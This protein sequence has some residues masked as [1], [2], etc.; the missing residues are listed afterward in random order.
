MISDKSAACI[1][2]AISAVVVVLLTGLAVLVLQGLQSRFAQEKNSVC[3]TSQFAHVRLPPN[4]LIKLHY[5]LRISHDM[6]TKLGVRYVAIG[7]TLLSIVRDGHL[8]PWDD[9]GDLAVF[10]DDYQKRRKELATEM[11]KNRVH[12]RDPFKV[13]DLG[14]FQ[15][16]LDDDHPLNA[17][18]PSEDKPFVDW[19][20]IKKHKGDI[21]GENVNHYY[22]FASP[23]QCMLWPKD[24]HTPDEMFPLRSRP[25]KI[26]SDRTALRHNLHNSSVRLAV[27]NIT[28]EPLNRSYGSKTDP[29]QWR[30]CYLA[31]SHR[32]ASLFVKPCQLTAEQKAQL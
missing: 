24:Y 19:M 26:F 21:N 10:A 18:F 16:V 17:Q 3:S 1:G 30:T 4:Y 22:H 5:L 6:F 13:A 25:L 31:S 23:R 11:A 8:T 15:L 14:V 12:L 2:V 29:E 27:P 20:L 32:S 9:D 28:V 7:G